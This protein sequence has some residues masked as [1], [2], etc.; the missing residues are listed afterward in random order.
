MCLLSLHNHVLSFEGK[1]NLC[2]NYASQLFFLLGWQKAILMKSKLQSYLSMHH[3]K[4]LSFDPCV[5]LNPFL[6][7]NIMPY[8]LFFNLLSLL[9]FIFKITPLLPLF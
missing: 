1:Q 9:V 2:T 6:I 5:I 8:Y 7:F 3:S 4:R